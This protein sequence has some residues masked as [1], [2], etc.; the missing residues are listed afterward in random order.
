[1][2]FLSTSYPKTAAICLTTLSVKGLTQEFKTDGIIYAAGWLETGATP[3]LTF[4]EAISAAF[5]RFVRR[6]LRARIANRRR[7]CPLFEL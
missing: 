3:F 1:L 7:F 2:D 6:F 4:P 5:W